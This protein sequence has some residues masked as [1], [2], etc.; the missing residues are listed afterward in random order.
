MPI[1]PPTHAPQRIKT[2]QHNLVDRQAKRLYRTNS[3]TWRAIRL[4]VLSECPLCAVC[5]CNGIIKAAN[6]VDHIDGDSHNNDRS[7]LQA[8]CKPCHSAK[9]VKENGG[10]GNEKQT[11]Y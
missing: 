2:K 1:R 10:F 9:T 7:N 3:K 11:N 4:E 6:E 5:M 8:L